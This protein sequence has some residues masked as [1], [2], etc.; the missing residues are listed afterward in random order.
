MSSNLPHSAGNEEDKSQ[1]TAGLSMGDVLLL[2]DAERKIVNWLVRQREATVVQVAAQIERSPQTVQELLDRLVEQGFIQYTEIEGE[3]RY[4]PRLAPKRNR[5][6][7][8]NIWD[9]LGGI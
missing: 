3:R 7:P 8:K 5:S 1:A 2:P 4:R 9:K 6:V